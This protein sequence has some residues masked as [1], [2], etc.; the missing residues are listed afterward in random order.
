MRIPKLTKLLALAGT[1]FAFTA[2][3]QGQQIY[4][5]T[6]NTDDSANWSRNFS[7]YSATGTGGTTF[8]SIS[9]N[10]IDFNFD[11]TSVGLPIAPH[12]ALFGSAAIHHGLK[13]NACYTNTATLKSGYV[14][15]G[16]S[17]APTNFSIT[18]NFVMHADMWINVD[19]DPFSVVDTN[20]LTDST[21][22]LANGD[23]ANSTAS[24]VFYGCG[25]GTAG[26]S[27]TMPGDTDAIWVGALTDNGSSAMYRMY[28]PS[29]IGASSYQ[30]GTYQ[31][32]GTVTPAFAGDPLVYNIGNGVQG[33]GTRNMIGSTGNPPYTQAEMSTN[34]ATG[35]PWRNLIPISP[36]PL[37]QQIL[38]HQQTNNYSLPGF[39]T[40]AWHDVSVE[41]I[42][43]VIVYKIDGNIIATGNYASAGTPPGTFLTFVASRTG[44]S[45]ASPVSATA[46]FYTNLNFVVFANI[47]VSNYNNVVNISAPTPT[48]QE[49]FPAE[50]GVFTF[51]RSSAGVPLTVN[52]T[53]TGT[54]T[55]GV[56]YQTIATNVTFNSTALTTNVNIVPIDDGIPSATKQVVL[57]LQS[58]NGYAGAGSA[59]VNLLDGDTPTVDISAP[60]GAQAYGRYTGS[61][62]NGNND[63]IPFVL[64]RRGNLTPASD[65]VV[66]LAYSGSAVGGT[67]FTPISSIDIPSGIQ[68][69]NLVIAPVYNPS[70]TTNRTVI[71]SV[72]SVANGAVG[73]GPASGTI[74][75]ANYPAPVAVL[76]SD[77]LQSSTDSTNWA[78]TYGTGDPVN[79]AQNYSADFGDSAPSTAPGGNT[80][81][82][83]LTCN[84]QIPATSTPA[85]G[86]VNCYFTNLFLSGNYAVR[87][88]MNVTEGQL[89]AADSEGPVFGINHTGTC[90]NW[91][92]GN[93]TLTGGPWASDGVWYWMNAQPNGTSAGDY[94]EFTGDGGTNG[95]AGWE[96]LA[97]GV[98][99]TFA[100]DFKDD[101]YGIYGPF[102]TFD[103]NGNMG[104]PG[105]PANASPEDEDVST[106]SDVEIKQ[107]NGVITMSIN[108]TPI[109]VYTNTTVWTNGYLMLGYEDPYGITVN[110]T[111]AGVYYANLQVVQLPSTTAIVM[112]INKI[113][114]SGGDV[115]ITFT[116][117]SSSDTTSS[118]TLDSSGTLNGTFSAASPSA[119]ITS[120]GGN[121]F[122]ATIPYAGGT[123]F[124]KIQH[125]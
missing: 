116:T 49:G 120:L 58:G 112:T 114:V 108:H 12:S 63:Y 70:I 80:A 77:D 106:W 57:T 83:F 53:V 86:A 8:N 119:T 38:Y 84:K 87:F 59:V 125:D 89:V 11:Y 52:Y 56:N 113:V 115:V 93:G 26:T 79:D 55:N 6:F 1:L 43:S 22:S 2:T 5:N 62:P 48:C 118:F 4:L 44:T 29:S 41:K 60:A 95:N 15:S 68:T 94:I 46:P 16:L 14:T 97:T 39:L 124:Y 64:T 82:L 90:S 92:Y 73:N 34:L 98:A 101:N 47:V 54:A 19:C 109:F 76:L 40:F 45:V 74:V 67:D 65:P 69:T 31:T 75:S 25:Y 105:I 42:G 21:A 24:T 37:A 88:N 96:Q 78:V 50:P 7:Y 85:P 10:L 33:L 35:V 27:A 91:W 81:A 61:A 17:V 100:Q 103:A 13:L 72:A 104:T 32:S 9:N 3:S 111:D 66:N 122:Q 71:A 18:A 99:A 110:T 20:Y 30:D 102:T 28:G 51:T 121:Q 36:V 107:V 123:Q 117:S 23:S